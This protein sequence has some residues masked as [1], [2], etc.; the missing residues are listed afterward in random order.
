MAKVVRKLDMAGV[1]HS[2]TFYSK[3][4]ELPENFVFYVLFNQALEFHVPVYAKS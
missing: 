2:P 3:E 1:G 4:V